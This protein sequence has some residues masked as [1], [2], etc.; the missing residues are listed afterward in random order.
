MPTTRNLTILIFEGVE[1][2]D[3]CGPFEGFAVA[4]RFTGPPAFNVLTVAEKP[5]AVLTRDGLSANPRRRLA[6]SPRPDLRRGRV[7]SVRPIPAYPSHGRLRGGA[8]RPLGAGR[9]A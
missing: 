6:D 7:W 5:G 8:E 4:N 1:V 9:R 3:F 2:P